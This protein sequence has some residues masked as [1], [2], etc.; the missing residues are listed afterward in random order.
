M[1]SKQI[2][3][4]DTFEQSTCGVCG[5]CEINQY[6]TIN[7]NFIEYSGVFLSL[8]EV[9]KEALDLRVSFGCE[10]SL[11]SATKVLISLQVDTK[12]LE[13]CLDCKD[14]VIKFYHFKRKVHDVQKTKTFRPGRERPRR[15]KRSKVVH[16][17]VQIVENYTEKC[18]VSTIKVD[19][20]S[21]KLII[22]P[23]PSHTAS[24]PPTATVTTNPKTASDNAHMNTN[25][26]DD[27]LDEMYVETPTF[28]TSENLMADP[29]NI[30]QEEVFGEPINYIDPSDASN[31][32]EDDMG[33]EDDSNSYQDPDYSYNYGASTSSQAYPPVSKKRKSEA[34]SSN[35]GEH[36]LFLVLVFSKKIVD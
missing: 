3:V 23:K 20:N 10:K 2:K 12:Q 36:S 35:E 4:S 30:K 18:N 22:E 28:D 25:E 27:L 31:M 33:D 14:K 11:R 24:A 13:I 21:R 29:V 15:E 9:L 34:K 19:E 7:D 6:F 8:R 17:I 32:N 1:A 26:N 16:N 5:C